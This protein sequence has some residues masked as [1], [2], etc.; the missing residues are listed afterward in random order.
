MVSNI[1]WV[2][3]WMILCVF[4][5]DPVN[6]VLDANTAF[7]RFRPLNF[8]PSH[9]HTIVRQYNKFWDSTDLSF[10]D[11]IAILL[12]CCTTVRRNEIKW[13]RLSLASPSSICW[14]CLSMCCL[15]SSSTSYR[16][17]PF[18]QVFGCWLLN[19]MIYRLFFLRSIA[20]Y[21]TQIYMKC[22][23]SS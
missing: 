19:H 18:V 6:N 4:I 5:V 14:E 7:V 21:F 1:C 3:L 20:Q 15:F 10:N 23:V 13:T 11:S 16:S 9:H 8:L 12:Y 22:F 2:R 17:T